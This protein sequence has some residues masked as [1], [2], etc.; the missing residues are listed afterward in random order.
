MIKQLVKVKFDVIATQDKLKILG[1]EYV[2][3]LSPHKIN[4]VVTVYQNKKMRIF[5]FV[6]ENVNHCTNE[7]SIKYSG[8]IFK[9][10]GTEGK[11]VGYLY[12]DISLDYEND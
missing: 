5:N 8:Y 7:V 1:E 2:E 9:L 10:D 11:Q 6:V 4:D 3:A 12:K